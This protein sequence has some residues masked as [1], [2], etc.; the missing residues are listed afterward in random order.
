MILIGS[1]VGFISLVEPFSKSYANEREKYEH[2]VE[3]KQM[4]EEENEKFI[5]MIG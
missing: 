2:K 1:T 3:K 4:S 5:K